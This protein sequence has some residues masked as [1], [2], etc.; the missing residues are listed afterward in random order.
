MQMIDVRE[1]TKTLNAY[2]V[3][4]VSKARFC[5][6]VP[7]QSIPE[8]K[9]LIEE[10]IAALEVETRQSLVLL[11][12]ISKKIAEQAEQLVIGFVD[13]LPD[14]IQAIH[15]SRAASDE[16]GKVLR[17]HEKKSESKEPEESPSAK[18][19]RE[20]RARL[21]QQQTQRKPTA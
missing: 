1:A 10:M 19:I 15:R 7:N 14:L 21:K 6:R 11:I 18:G 13:E 17:A 20:F 16:A 3:L 5:D 4:I 8:E 9:E 2:S 12:M